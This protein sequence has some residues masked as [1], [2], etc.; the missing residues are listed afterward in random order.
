[1][2]NHSL[3]FWK[4]SILLAAAIFGIIALGFIG[5]WLMMTPEEQ[6][7]AELVVLKVVPFP[8][9]S[10]AAIFFVIAGLVRYLF[11]SFITPL[12]EMAEETRIIAKVNAEHRIELRGAE[13]V[14]EIAASINRSANDY[15]LLQ[16]DVEARIAESR[17]ELEKEHNRMIALM[18]ELPGGVIYVP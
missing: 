6:F 2:N 5:S 8:L 4:I 16:Q 13:P 11:N 17:E 15:L 18:S 9:G 3:K 10:A 14:K 7:F 1:M 12:L